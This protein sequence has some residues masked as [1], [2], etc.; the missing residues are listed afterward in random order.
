M[1][2]LRRPTENTKFWSTKGSAMS[3]DMEEA[4]MFVIVAE[5]TDEAADVAMFPADKSTVGAFLEME[6]LESIQETYNAAIA[7][8]NGKY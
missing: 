7:K 6:A 1:P 8:A 4:G 2:I 3:A 5:A